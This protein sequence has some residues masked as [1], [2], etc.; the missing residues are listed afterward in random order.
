MSGGRV[1]WAVGDGEDPASPPA[2]AGR[3]VGTHLR[4]LRKDKGLRL[5]DVV[6]AGLVGSAPTLSRIENGTTPLKADMVLRLAQH[7]GVTDD[8]VLESL[9]KLATRSRD[10]QW[11]EEFRDVIP[12]WVERLISVES[13]AQEIRTYEVQYVPGLLQT[14]AYAR[15]LME[16]ALPDPSVADP[17]KNQMRRERAVKL[18]QARRALLQ[19]AGAPHYYALV[20]EAVLARPVGGA[21]VMRGQLR[22]LYSLEENV[23]W[24]HIRVL[25][26]S[27]GAEAMAPAPSITYLSFPA[28]REEDMV[29]LE[30]RNGGSY[31]T[32]PE[33]VERYRLA[34]TG[35][36]A[37]AATR[38]ETLALLDQYI[39][40]L[41]D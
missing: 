15:V 8:K 39:A 24:I 38:E 26:F 23:E 7:Y 35:L 10:A 14:P 4:R 1:L 41:A 32:N 33:D 16:H 9:V 31:L 12:G 37:M 30:V 11:F 36:W 25:P 19:E 34:L 13:A 22:E 18:R 5:V 29:Y 6:K 2:G 27:K 17:L 21:A 40:K 20:D 3:V 28:D